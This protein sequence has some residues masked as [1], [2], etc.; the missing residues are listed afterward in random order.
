MPNASNLKH[1]IAVKLVAIKV[2]VTHNKGFQYFPMKIKIRLENI[3]RPKKFLALIL[4]TL[5]LIRIF[6]F[7]QAF[8]N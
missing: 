2:S 8:T 4:E 5:T 6:S 7:A 3:L 1:L